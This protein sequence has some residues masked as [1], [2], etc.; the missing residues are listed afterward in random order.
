MT[1]PGPKRVIYVAIAAN[2]A[3]AGCKYVAATFTSRPSMLAEA[4][5]TTVAPGDELLLL[6]GI[7][8]GARPAD[9]LHPYGHGK[10]LY[11]YS[12]LVAVYIFRA[13]RMFAV[14][15]GILHLRQ[16]EMSKNVV[17]AYTVLALSAAFELYSWRTSY[18]ELRLQR[19]EHETIWDQIIASKDPTIFTIFLEDSAGLIGALL[20]FLGIF[21]GH[22][23]D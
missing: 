2:L 6:F 12:L 19:D 17:W 21:L 5:H 20:A 4:V 9:S 11:F 1:S 3:I 15:E 10:A 16:P 18:R 7:K 14:Y 22:L 13:G 23:L 8:R